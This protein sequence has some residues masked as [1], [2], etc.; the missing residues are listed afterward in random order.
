MPCVRSE[1][2]GSTAKPRDSVY[3]VS[4]KNYCSLLSARPSGESCAAVLE[5]KSPLFHRWFAR[6]SPVTLLYLAWHLPSSKSTD[7]LVQLNSLVGASSLRESAKD[8]MHLPRGLDAKK[9]HSGMLGLAL[10]L[11]SRDFAVHWTPQNQ[12]DS[13]YCRTARRTLRRARRSSWNQASPDSP[14]HSAFRLGP[15]V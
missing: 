7:G 10:A 5:P 9:A 15:R 1:P 12:D 3:L 4:K 6:G 13:G 11:V 2:L 14:A 8:Q